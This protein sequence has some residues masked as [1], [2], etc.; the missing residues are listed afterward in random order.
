LQLE[1]QRSRDVDREA[2]VAERKGGIEGREDREGGRGGG[3]K[4]RGEMRERRMAWV[5]ERGA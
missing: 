2:Q 4:R 3:K 5:T 1:H